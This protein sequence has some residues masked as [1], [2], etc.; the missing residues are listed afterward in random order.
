M[1]RTTRLVAVAAALALLT[2][3]T[4]NPAEPSE[5]TGG[6]STSAT[7]S[8]RPTR[9]SSELADWADA[10]E[11]RD[12][13]SA[14]WVAVGDSI[15]EG[16]GAST[17]DSRWIDLTLDGL[18]ERYPT[19]DAPGGVGYRPTAFAVA[20]PASTWAR[21]ATSSE[22][23]V[24]V[25]ASSRTA[26][27]GYRSVTLGADATTTYPFT[28]TDLDLWW[29]SGRGTF[30]Y[31][32]DDGD[33]VEVDTRDSMATSGISSVTGLDAG[34]H[35][36]T[37]HAETPVD[38][39]GLTAFDGDRDRGITLFDS[40]R[41]GATARTFT[42]DLPG[43]LDSIAATKPDLVTITL[44]ANDA[45]SRTPDQFEDDYR[46]LIDGLQSLD[47]PPSIMLMGEFVPGTNLTK[48]LAADAGDYDAVVR[49]LAD[50]TGS[51][52]V[53]LADALPDDG[54][55]SLL[56][57]DGVHPNDAGQRVIADYVLGQL[58]VY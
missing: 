18:R 43:Y 46:T 5:P 53:D 48:G 34:A 44:G 23:S 27:L 31:T 45:F 14:R 52:Y 35:T 17:V 47:D 7:S 40:S 39:E 22:G 37:I 26:D 20:P 16:M 1:T 21:W 56:S 50:E 57:G 51:A 24:S 2:G 15:P 36:V 41:S 25:S 4:A 6:A 8:P 33:A 54:L 3:C 30:S 58:S 55:A 11:G 19:E 32:V 9:A 10:L 38:I 42:A 29:S 28:G 12:E 13:Y 49:R